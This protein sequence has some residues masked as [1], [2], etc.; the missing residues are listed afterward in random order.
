[1]LA[2]AG[3]GSRGIVFGMRNSGIGHVF[4]A[5]NQHGVIRF[6]DGQTGKAAE[7]SPYIK[8][9]FLRTW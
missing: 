5:A 4:N 6:L 1:M 7:I 9:Q 2:A 3:P 8:F